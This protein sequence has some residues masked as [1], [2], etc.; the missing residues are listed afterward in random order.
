[1][2]FSSGHLSLDIGPTLIQSGFI[3][4]NYISKDCFQIR[5]HLEMP[6]GH[7]WRRLGW[8]QGDKE[9]YSTQYFW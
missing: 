9:H 5:L 7:E 6:S 8:G 1:M 4:T 3:L 2:A